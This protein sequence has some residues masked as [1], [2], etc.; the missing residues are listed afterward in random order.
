MSN[1]TN[2]QGVMVFAEHEAGKLSAITIELMGKAGELAAELGER[3]EAIILGK[4][5]SS[6]AQE[7]IYYG[8]DSVLVGDSKELDHYQTES[9]TTFIVEEV[10][11]RKPEILLFGATDTGRDLAPRVACRLGAGLVADCTE[12]SLDKEKRRLL[13]T[14]PGFGG[15][16][17][18]T[19]VCPRT[20]PQ[21][22]TVPPG[23][24]R[25]AER[26]EARKGKIEQVNISLSPRPFPLKVIQRVKAEREDI[27]LEEAE[28]IVAG[29]RGMGGA[30]GLSLIKELARLMGAELGATKDVC[31]A[32]WLSEEHMIGQ[33]G[34]MVKP[35]L[36]FGCGISGAIQ[37]TVGLRDVKVIVA[38]NKDAN[39]EIFKISD[40][41]LIADLNEVLPILIE[42]LKR[43]KA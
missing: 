14:K 35:N 16:I 36:Y 30:E 38:I 18:Y 7:L 9:Y 34:K 15:K 3:V 20:F 2:F 37:H 8:A 19:F 43:G 27:R 10:Q 6:L 12:L 32:G 28:V 39:A 13:Q 4:G 31:D 26:N 33:T 21:M 11:K 25:P 23:I 40:Y 41:G 29:G 42:E 5:I 17:M 1:A 24:L 22:A